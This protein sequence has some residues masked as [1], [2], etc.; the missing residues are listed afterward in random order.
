LGRL[1]AVEVSR[2]ILTLALV[3]ALALAGANLLGMLAGA[4]VATF[5][6]LALLAWIARSLIVIKLEFDRGFWRELFA[7]TLPYAIALSIAAVYVYVT[8]IIVSLIASAT[9]TGLFATSFRVT[10]ALLAIPSLLLTAVFPLMV[11]TRVEHAGDLGEAVGR[12]FAVALICGVWMS[13]AVALGADVIV[14][15]IAGS[16]GRGA[17]SVLRI[18]ALVLAVSF[19]STSSALALASLRRYRALIISSCAALA[20]D[21]GLGLALVPGLGARGGAIAD[22]LTEA[23]AALGLTV[24]V[25]R[26]VPRHGIRGSL[27]PPLLLA[28]GLAASVLLLPIGS[29]PR[30]LCATSIYFGV[31]AI[32]HAIPREVIDAAGRLGRSTPRA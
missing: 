6:A 11:R 17:T 29:V 20:L 5:L 27:L 22:V 3:G 25:T 23:A 2:R 19:L 14:H 24:A 10:G 28:C 32:T 12:V 9:Q 1:A 18:Q 30:V 31:L 26:A 8:V 4:S 7:E 21:I 16:P 13:L 15:L